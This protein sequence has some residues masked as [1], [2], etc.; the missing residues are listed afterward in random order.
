MERIEDGSRGLGLCS[1]ALG[2]I[3]AKTYDTESEAAYGVRGS[4]F[5][6]YGLAIASKGHLLEVSYEKPSFRYSPDLHLVREISLLES[7]R[8]Q[9]RG[10]FP[11]PCRIKHI[12]D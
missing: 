5:G 12:N 10:V 1:H 8:N 2:V 3:E 7:S 4:L 9:E 6:F 11:G